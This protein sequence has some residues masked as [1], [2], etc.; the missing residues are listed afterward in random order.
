MRRDDLKYA[1]QRQ[2]HLVTAL[3]AGWDETNSRVLGKT[4]SAENDL[5]S[6]VCKRIFFRLFV[7]PTLQCAVWRESLQEPYT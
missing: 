7:A 6:S 4:A 2:K 5:S 3:I 1:C